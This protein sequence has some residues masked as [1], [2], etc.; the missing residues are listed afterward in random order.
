MPATIISFLL[1]TKWW[2]ALPVD[3]PDKL[4]WGFP[5]A[6]V[7]EGFHTS[8]SLQFFIFEWVADALIYFL[9]WLA[10]FFF[11]KS[12]KSQWVIK[13]TVVRF[14]WSLAIVFL[15]GAG[16]LVSISNPVFHF[17][18]PY[19]WQVMETGY[20]FIWQ[21]TPRPDIG[22]YHSGHTREESHSAKN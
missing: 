21:Q 19:E 16:V 14:V 10:I 22:K 18:R 1:F 12:F 8:G 3:G 9:F 20:T 11:L 7:G 4:Y 2:F 15:M 13:K 5:F 17:K 6:F